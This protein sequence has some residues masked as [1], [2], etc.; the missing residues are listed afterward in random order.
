MQN[1]IYEY[2]YHALKDKAKK[3]IINIQD[4]KLCLAHRGVQ[5]AYFYGIIGEMRKKKLIIRMNQQ[6]I[7]IADKEK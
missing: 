4:A 6:Y 3:D 1:T 7:K 5:K 2:Y